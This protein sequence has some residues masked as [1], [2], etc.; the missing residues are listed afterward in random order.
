MS[1]EVELLNSWTDQAVPVP[2]GA[3]DETRDLA[4]LAV[5]G[6]IGAE[7]GAPPTARLPVGQVT[8]LTSLRPRMPPLFSMKTSLKVWLTIS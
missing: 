1:I 4:L 6:G 8:V 7:V 3:L 2:L 5:L